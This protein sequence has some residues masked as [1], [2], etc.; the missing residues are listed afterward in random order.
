MPRR[1][2]PCAERDR[3][4]LPGCA[5]VRAVFWISTALL[6]WAQAGYGVFLELLRRFGTRSDEIPA[7]SAATPRVS[8]IVAAYREQDVIAEKVANT[9]ALDW[10]REALE[11]IVAV[12]GGAEPDADATAEQARAAGADVVLELPRAG[13]YRAQDAAVAAASGEL[14]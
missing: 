13:K 4:H 14:L 11:L 5:A 3:C 6:A 10:P 1:I 7:Q 12:D 8:L 2:L 9:L